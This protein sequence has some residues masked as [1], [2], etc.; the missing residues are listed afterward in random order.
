MTISE[1]FFI[2]RLRVVFIPHLLY[3]DKRGTLERKTRKGLFYNEEL[4]SG[5]QP[6]V[7]TTQ[8]SGRVASSALTT[9]Q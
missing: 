5:S 3:S 1:S 8:A 7:H 6:S 4:V 9:V 2:G